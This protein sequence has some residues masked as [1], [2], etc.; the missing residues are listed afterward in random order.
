MK[1]QWLLAVGISMMLVF[2]AYAQET[3][4]VQA[5]AETEAETAGMDEE[6]LEKNLDALGQETFRSTRQ[7]FK[8]GGVIS[9]GY[10]GDAGSGLQ[11]ML[12]DFG[13]D[14]AIDGAV[15]AKTMEALHHVQESFGLPVT[16]EVNLA[17]FDTM[18]PLLLLTK[19]DVDTDVDLYDYFEEAGGSGYYDYLQGCALMAQ[20]KY[21]SAKE[22]FENSSYGD[23]QE[24]AEACVQEMP[25]NGEIWRNPDI[26]GSD[27]SLTFI[28]NSEDDTKGMCF[29][30]YN[31]DNQL[32]SVLFIKGNGSAITYVPTGTYHIKDGVGYEWYGTTETF[33]PYG[34]YEYLT[35]SEDEDTMFDAYLDYGQYELAINVSEIEEGAT[36]VGAS[37]VGWDE[38]F[39]DTAEN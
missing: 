30:M 35:F 26:P 1:K 6:S 5:Q 24:K 3:E 33:G 8:D 14:I 29:Q 34:Y 16:D 12:V 39:G 15:G 23:S 17:Q 18:L 13:C 38:S 32:V 11:Q 25:S 28:V 2:P 9:S 27:S 7:F 36:S 10:K 19:G 20:G 21:Y 4:T 31:S 22:A 37:S